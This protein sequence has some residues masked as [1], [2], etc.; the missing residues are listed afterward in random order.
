MEKSN[1]VGCDDQIASSVFK[2]GLPTKHNLDREFAIT[3]SQTLAEVFTTAEHYELW[4]DDCI[5]VKKSGKQVDHPPKEVVH[6]ND[7]SY[8]G[9]N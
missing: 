2:N 9:N 5:A 3:L 8:D 7:G 1:I 4:D 6:K